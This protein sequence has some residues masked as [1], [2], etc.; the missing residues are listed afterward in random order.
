MKSFTPDL[1]VEGRVFRIGRL[2]AEG[3]EYVDRPEP[4]IDVLR[5]NRAV[6]LFTFM[7]RLPHTTPKYAYPLEWDNLAALPI[8]TFDEWWTKRIDGKTRNMVRRG[9]KKGL[10]V[11]EVEFDGQLVKGIHEIYNESAIRLGR[12]FPHYGKDEDT[13]RRVSATFM[14][15]SIFMAAFLETR[16]VGFAKLTIDE[17]RSQAAIMHIVG[18]IRHRDKSITNALIA[19][20]VRSCESRKIPY[21]VYANFSYGKKQRDGLS[22]F[23][24]SNGFQRID[25]PRYY[26]PITRAGALAL[27]LGIHRRVVDFL[28]GCLVKRFRELRS[29]WYSRKFPSILQ[30]S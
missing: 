23:K 11:R 10:L 3:F 27:Q 25:L 1:R 22:D 20:A 2:A 30:S 28:P 26:V 5:Q 13:V 19:Q 21:L 29:G 15:S 24:D 8:S 18:M 6:D 4:F 7:Q 12:P 16:I 9:E 17:A 14:E